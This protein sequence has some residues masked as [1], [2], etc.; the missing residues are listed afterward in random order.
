MGKP[1]L[2]AGRCGDLMALIPESISRNATQLKH[3]SCGVTLYV[4]K[5]V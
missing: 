5:F 4:H 1:A 3:V 2:I